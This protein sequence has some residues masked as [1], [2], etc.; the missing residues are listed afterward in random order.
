MEKILRD[1]EDKL[2]DI[3]AELDKVGGTYDFFEV[4]K[5]DLRY[6]K[7]AVENSK[8]SLYK[9]HKKALVSN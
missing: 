9:F 4:T 2:M 7:Y 5:S 1:Y 3:P 6:L 8:S